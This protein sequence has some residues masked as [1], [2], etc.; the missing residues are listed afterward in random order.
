MHREGLSDEFADVSVALFVKH[1]HR[2]SGSAERAAEQTGS[3]QAQDFGEAGNELGTERL[4]QAVIER[5]R[6]S[7]RVAGGYRG[8]E[9]SGALDVEGGIGARVDVGEHG[10]RFL[11]GESEVR[12]H[13]G[14]PEVS[15]HGKA[16][17]PRIASGFDGAGDYRTHDARG[18]V[19]RMT[20]DAGGF[21]EN[22]G[23]LP[24]ESKQARAN[25]DTRGDRGRAGAEAFTQGNLIDNLQIGRRQGL[26]D[27][28]GHSE[29]GLPDEVVFAA[30]DEGCVAAGATDGQ[31]VG[32]SKSARE[33][34]LKGDAKSIE[35]GTE[36]GAGAGNAKGGDGSQ[37]A[38]IQ[39]RARWLEKWWSDAGTSR[40]ITLM[41]A[42]RYLCSHLV[43]LTAGGREQWVNLEEIWRDGAVMECEEAV[44]AGV[45]ATIAADGARFSGRV[46]RVESHEFGWTVEV[47]LSL[48][49][50]WSMERWTPEHA[51]E[52]AKYPPR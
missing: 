44:A 47:A 32:G 12:H 7:R 9:Q 25:D 24:V 36:I 42:P 28:A 50:P 21:V 30:G 23:G 52:L 8:D 11:R 40:K 4:V 35:A 51:L 17:S 20:F 49:T 45:G 37:T 39:S 2:R 38:I 1:Q 48:L 29:S 43:R 13:N 26:M 14:N 6:E 18:H 15:G 10:A 41:A 27:A 34:N 3:A 19:I 16:N 46:T 33:I 22:A 31:P 5:G